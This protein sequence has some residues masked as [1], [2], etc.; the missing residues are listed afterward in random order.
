MS[1]DLMDSPRWNLKHSAARAIAEAT[2]SLSE[3]YDGIAED[4]AAVLWPGLRKA[5]DGKTWEGKEV[6][7]EAFAKFADKIRPG[8]FRDKIAPEVVKV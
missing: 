7:V 5:V 1:L 6:V 4:Q 2:T 8:E 3:G